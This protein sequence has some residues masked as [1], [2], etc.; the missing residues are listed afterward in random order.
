[1]RVLVMSCSASKVP[2]MGPAP[3]MQVYDGPMWRDLRRWV[4]AHPV[5][6]AV[7]LEV[8]VLSAKHGLIPAQTKIEDYNLKMT[9]ERAA[10][11]VRNREQIAAFDAML[12]GNGD[13]E[14][15]FA[16][17]KLYADTLAK[18]VPPDYEWHA[19]CDNGARGNGEIRSRL[20]KWL[21]TG[22]PA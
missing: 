12:V 1:M 21:T 13:P 8:W 20:T 2:Q 11:L 19:A 7:H 5:D 3:A 6:A 15:Y 4:K 18:M 14:L 10:E 16:G 9:A 17:G 22:E